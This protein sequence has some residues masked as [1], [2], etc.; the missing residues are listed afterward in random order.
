MVAR[1]LA[2]HGKACRREERERRSESEKLMYE[3]QLI[4]INTQIEM[5]KKRLWHI[6]LPY[7][8]ISN[9]QNFVIHVHTF[10]YSTNS[11]VRSFMLLFFIAREKR[12][13]SKWFDRILMVFS[14]KAHSINLTNENLSMC[15]RVWVCE[16]DGEYI[17]AE[18]EFIIEWWIK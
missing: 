12:V 14:G 3:P 17:K 9:A 6:L 11:F 2:C 5:N 7:T 8:G 16:C 18:N 13:F 4:N 10:S 1:N 15:A